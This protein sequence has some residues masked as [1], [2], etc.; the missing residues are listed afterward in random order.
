MHLELFAVLGL[1]T[2]SLYALTALGIIIVHRASGVL[3]FASGAMGALAAFVVYDLRDN[4]G[5][6]A[7]VAVALGLLLGAAIGVATQLVV[8][9]VLRKAP[10]IT[11]LI[12]TL[13]ILSVLEGATFVAYGQETLGQPLS[14]FPTERRELLPG[15]MVPEDRMWLI[16]IAVVAALLLKALYTKTPFGLTTSAVAENRLVAA[17]CG[18]SVTR[19]EVANFAIAGSVSAAAPS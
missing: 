19:V 3:N 12:A 17:M 10:P 18:V 5:V 2:G 1:A 8:M 7:G 14:M 4:H 11:K 16:G 9:T 13:G 6:P 15:T